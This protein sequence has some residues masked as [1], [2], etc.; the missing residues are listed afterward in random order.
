VS[1]DHVRIHLNH[2]PFQSIS[3]LV[4]RLKAITSRKIQQE[5]PEFLK[6]KG[7][8]RHFLTIGLVRWRD[9]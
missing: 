4:K 7:F 2:R 1:K 6:K 8:V 9:F 3:E 5:F